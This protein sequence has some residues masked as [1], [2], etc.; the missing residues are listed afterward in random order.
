[1]RWKT[2][3]SRRRTST[4]SRPRANRRR[5][6]ATTSDPAELGRWDQRRRL[7]VHAAR[8][9]RGGRDRGRALPHRTHHAR[10]ER[11]LPGGRGGFGRPG[12]SLS[13]QFEM[14]FGPAGPPTLFTLPVLRFMKEYGVSEEQLAMVAVVQREWAAMNPRGLLSR[15]DQRRRR[16]RFTDDRVPVP[17]AHVLPRDRRRRRPD[18]DPPPS[19]PA[20][21]RLLLCTSRARGRASRLRW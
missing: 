21:S 11:P 14:P 16:P 5:R 9:P 19:A 20:T 1:M 10:R 6:C 2:R 4:G 15:A 3:G 17:Q 13:G 7:L 12:A 18:P 8:A